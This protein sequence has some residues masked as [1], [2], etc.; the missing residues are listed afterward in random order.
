MTAKNYKSDFDF[1]QRVVLCV[2]HDD[3]TC[4]K[5][6]VGWPD[7]DWT[8]TY[9]TY[10]RANAYVASCIGGVC[11]NCFNDNGR[12][13]VIVHDH[14]LG[15]GE[16]RVE[17]R[18]WLP[19]DIYP[20]GTQK[21]V[22]PA[23]TG[24]ELV[25]GPGDC[26]TE[27]EVEVMLPYIKGDPGEPGER[28]PQGPQ[29]P[30]GEAGPQGEPGASAY[31]LAV[32]GGYEGSEDE[33]SAALADIASI[34][35]QPPQW[36]IDVFEADPNGGFDREH[37]VFTL[38]G[39]TLT[40]Q[41]AMATAMRG[42]KLTGNSDYCG[43]GAAAKIRANLTPVNSSNASYCRSYDYLFRGQTQLEVAVLSGYNNK[44]GTE[45]NLPGIST[46]GTM[47]GMFDGCASLRK[48]LG[49]VYMVY[50][51]VSTSSNNAFRGCVALED[52]WLD[53]IRADINMQDC[54]RLSLWTMQMAIRSADNS[55]PIT[56]T[57]H[58]DVY[59]K[60]T[61]EANTE[62][63]QVLVDAAVRDIIFATI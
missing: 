4:S 11:T 26:P 19:N 39:L 12:I 9:Y 36:L 46:M 42:N 48:V 47:Y 20:G 58:P 62:W 63:H 44:G 31:D 21:Q 49:F 54:G 60:L 5:T 22:E 3:G 57:V 1:I 56:F 55:K 40:V 61:D 28:G 52:I 27:I 18:A 2:R 8:A 59:A 15:K 43:L 34:K 33:F 51:G 53:R 17:L 13:H 24:I 16:L 45:L 37:M 10:N 14:Y 6:D 23:P 30:S 50:A 35:N 25:D 41:E 7:Y 38:H 32:E 29:G